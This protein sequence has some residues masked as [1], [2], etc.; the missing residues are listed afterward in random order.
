MFGFRAGTG[1]SNFSR[2][3]SGTCPKARG[4]VRVLGHEKK[5]LS[6]LNLAILEPKNCGFGSHMSNLGNIILLTVKLEC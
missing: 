1:I 2:A 3:G 4:R 6:T 5:F